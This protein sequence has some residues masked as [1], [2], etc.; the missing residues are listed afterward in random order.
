MG[1]VPE[2]RQYLTNPP[3]RFSEHVD[4]VRDV[5]RRRDPSA[6]DLSLLFY[7]SGDEWRLLGAEDMVQESAAESAFVEL[8][9]AGVPWINL[10]PEGR[11]DK[12]TYVVAIEHA[13]YVSRMGAEPTD[14]LVPGPP[15]LPSTDSGQ[16]RTEYPRQRPT[17][18]GAWGHIPT[19]RGVG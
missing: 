10:A 8:C 1:S 12:D 5:L 11:W 4:R 16:V 18:V 9:R 15:F 19:K 14:V 6:A 13:T 2:K 3:A 17:W 7:C